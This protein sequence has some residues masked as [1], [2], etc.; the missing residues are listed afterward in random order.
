MMNAAMRQFDFKKVLIANRG[1]I[2]CRIIRTL[3]NSGY[4]SVAV[5]SDADAQAMH[6][7]LADESVC[8]GAAPAAESYLNMAAIL[9]A[10]KSTGADAVHPGYG[11]LSENAAFSRA[12]HEAGLVFIGPSAAAIEA[13]GDK[14]IAKRHM[15]E[16]GVPTVPGYQDDRQSDAELLAAAGAVGFPL[17]V[18]AVAGGGGRGMRLVPESSQLQDAINS[19]R[20]EAASSFGDD[21]LL[22]E[23]FI[24]AGRHIEIQVFADAHGNAVHLG[25]RDCTAQR[26]RQKVLEEAPSP[27]VDSVMR[28]AMGRDAVAAALAVDYCGAG[29]VEFIVDQNGTHYFLEMNTRLQVEHPV[30]EMITGL[31]LVAW[32][33]QI[34]AGKPLPL[35]QHQVQ[36]TGHALEARLY[37]ENP[38]QGY[39]PETGRIE[40][41]RPVSDADA[42]LRIDNGVQE[43]ATV[44]PFYDPML[45]KFIVH[46][47]DRDDA[48]RRMARLLTA[49]PLFGVRNNSR[50]LYDLIQHPSFRAAKMHTAMMDRW[51]DEG[52]PMLQAPVAPAFAWA[53]AAAL[54]SGKPCWRPAGLAQFTL[55][56]HCDD[57]NGKKVEVCKKAQSIEL[58][59]E[60]QSFQVKILSADDN[61]MHYEL[62]GVRAEMPFLHKAGK[63]HLSIQAGV[64]VFSE[65]N[66]LE[67]TDDAG[68]GADLFAPMAGRVVRVDVAAGD[69]VTVGQALICLE[70]MKMEVW[71]KARTAGRVRAVHASLDQQIEANALLIE[72]DEIS[73][74]IK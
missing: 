31:D 11:F 20:R 58:S 59:F 72:C 50:L 63:L 30:T 53:L 54:F 4:A 36:F 17:L 10:A 1:E 64:F 74:E 8:I 51:L 43:A 22:L 34:A 6:V 21:R 41:W 65:K 35:Q 57:G 68:N 55:E 61:C 26:R 12:C 13:M 15:I 67:R 71:L 44:T 45:A 29:T 9:A 62:N 46:G 14:A 40:Y 18:K 23:R 70:A 69:D 48:I 52:E 28:E 47:R 42:G 16:A 37:A 24:E 27:I 2:A 49:T 38:Y 19:A 5:Y 3:R 66:P 33:L 39:S 56:L 73:V 25:E 7:K 32:Q 60:Q